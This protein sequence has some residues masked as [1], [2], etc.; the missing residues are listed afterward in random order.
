MVNHSSSDSLFLQAYTGLSS[1]AAD[2]IEAHKAG[3]DGIANTADD[4][5]FSIIGDIDS[6]AGITFIQ[7]G[8]LRKKNRTWSGFASPLELRLLQ[9]LNSTANAVEIELGAGLIS[10]AAYAI[11]DYRNGFDATQ[12]TADDVIFYLYQ[13]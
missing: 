6:V 9:Y 4:V 13:L 2:A 5:R 1:T 8:K 10:T 3:L 7:I 11:V 12:G